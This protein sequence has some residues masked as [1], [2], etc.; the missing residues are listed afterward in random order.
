MKARMILRKRISAAL[1]LEMLKKPGSRPSEKQMRAIA[2]QQMERAKAD[3]QIPADADFDPLADFLGE[4]QPPS[5][6]GVIFDR[7]TGRT[8]RRRG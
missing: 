8:H 6:D 7:A 1:H 3:D 5:I 2:R 4:S